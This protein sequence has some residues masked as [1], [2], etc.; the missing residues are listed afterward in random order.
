MRLLL[1]SAVS[2]LMLVSACTQSGTA[3]RNAAYG[4]AAGAVGGAITGCERSNECWNRA[5]NGDRRYYDQRAGRYYYVD[6]QYGDTWWEN[7]EFRSYGP[8]RP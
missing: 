7:G 5:R 2:G 4:A 1:S 3:E 8:G 6:P